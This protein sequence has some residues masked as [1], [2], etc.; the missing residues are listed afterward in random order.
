MYTFCDEITLQTINIESTAAGLMSANKKFVSKT[1]GP[2]REHIL[3]N[4]LLVKILTKNVEQEMIEGFVKR[5]KFVIKFSCKVRINFFKRMLMKANNLFC[6]KALS[7]TGE[8]FSLG[9]NIQS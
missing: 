3:S 8:T 2:L 4:I 1:K 5:S 9:R 7:H 6:I